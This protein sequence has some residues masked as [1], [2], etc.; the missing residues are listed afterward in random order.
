M[1]KVLKTFCALLFILNISCPHSASFKKEKQQSPVVDVQPFTD[2]AAAETQY[3]FDEIK[4]VYPGATLKNP[5]PLPQS[6]FYSIRNRYR[7]DSLIQFLNALTGTGHV[8]IGLTSKDISTTKDS[9][10]DWGVMGLGFCPGKACIASTFRLSKTEKLMQ[11][12]KVAIHESGHTQGLPHCVVKSCFMR[13]AEGRN[14]TNEEKDF[15][16]DCKKYSEQKGWVFKKMINQY[17][18]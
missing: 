15:C 16:V 8:T 17:S 1:F 3:V 14:P 4:K 12:F 5:I 13:D 10:A 6:A 2:M 11:L 18:Q 7:A 9:V